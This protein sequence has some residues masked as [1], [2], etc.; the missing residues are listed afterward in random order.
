MTPQECFLLLDG[1]E[2]LE[3]FP[4]QV[5]DYIMRPAFALITSIDKDECTFGYVLQDG[6][7]FFDMDD[8]DN[9]TWHKLSRC[10]PDFMNPRMFDRV[11]NLLEEKGY[12]HIEYCCNCCE[13]DCYV[14]R[15]NKVFDDEDEGLLVK[16]STRIEA[17]VKALLHAYGI[18]EQNNE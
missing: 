13:K 10:A 17:A 2:L 9:L 18:K 5:G 12:N 14:L 11:L 7:L 8:N 16:G 3:K 15:A 6:D 4:L 1:T